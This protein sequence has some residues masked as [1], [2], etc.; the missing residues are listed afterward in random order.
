MSAHNWIDLFQILSNKGG[1]LIFYLKRLYV[2][3]NNNACR[4]SS[5]IKENLL[6]I[7]TLCD[8]L[9]PCSLILFISSQVHPETYCGSLEL[10][11][12]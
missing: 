10:S 8:Y 9:C 11:E 1:E 7:L 4:V 12:L 5:E 3:N 6:L 2:L